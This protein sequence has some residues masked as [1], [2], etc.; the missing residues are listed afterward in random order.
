[1]VMGI[2]L[3]NLSFLGIALNF[4]D[5]SDRFR[6]FHCIDYTVVALVKNSYHAR[7]CLIASIVNKIV[8]NIKPVS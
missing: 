5:L 7:H 8:V 1:M 3:D 4:F 2:Y 6:I